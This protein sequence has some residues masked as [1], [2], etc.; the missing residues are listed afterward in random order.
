M[1]GS[2]RL[3]YKVC[4]TRPATAGMAPGLRAAHPGQAAIGRHPYEGERLPWPY[5]SGAGHGAS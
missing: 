2:V 1:T 4:R 5:H 3:R